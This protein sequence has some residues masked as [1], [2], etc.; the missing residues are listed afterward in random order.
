MVHR[1]GHCPGRDCALDPQRAMLAFVSAPSGSGDFRRDFS[2]RFIG[3]D[4]IGIPIGIASQLFWS[5]WLLGRFD[6]CFRVLI[7]MTN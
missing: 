1:L 3:R 2:F 7:Q 4:L 6:R 5:D